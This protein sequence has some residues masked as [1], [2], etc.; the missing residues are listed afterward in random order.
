MQRCDDVKVSLV[1]IRLAL[2]ANIIGG[3]L[4]KMQARNLHRAGMNTGSSNR[5]KHTQRQLQ[6][7]LCSATTQTTVLAKVQSEDQDTGTGASTRLLR[8]VCDC[9]MAIAAHGGSTCATVSFS[10]NHYQPDANL[11]RSHEGDNAMNGSRAIWSQNLSRLRRKL[12][13]YRHLR[14]KVR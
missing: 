12:G 3:R 8:S 5:V 14:N 11:D 10:Y 6:Q 9:S 2:P 13:G 7:C 1:G 4:R